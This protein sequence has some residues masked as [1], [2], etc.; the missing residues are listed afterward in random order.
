MD[1][2][3]YVAQIVAEIS[4]LRSQ[5][6]DAAV[7]RLVTSLS[8]KTCTIQHSDK[9]GPDALMGGSNY[10]ARILFHDGSSPW[11]LRVPRVTNF[12]AGLPES[13]VE[14]LVTSEHATL[15]FLENTK[16]PAPRLYAYG[17]RGTN[18]R[19]HGVGVSF[20]I[21]EH[22]PGKA[23]DGEGT[24]D[25]KAKVLSGLASIIYELSQHPF[26][27]AGSLVPDTLTS[28]RVSAVA[29]DRFLALTPHGPFD[30]AESYYTSFAEQHL[31]LICDGQLYTEYPV[32][33]YLVYRFLKESASQLASRD[34]NASAEFFLKHVDDKGDHI[35]VDEDFNITG[36]IDWE[37]ARTVPRLEAFGPSLVT[38]DMN[39]LC[40]GK[41]GL[42]EHDQIL[43]RELAKLS[44]RLTDFSVDEK[45]RRFF[46]GLAMEPAWEDAKPLAAA[47]LEV[48]GVGQ[49]W[50]AWRGDALERYKEDERL[51]R[52]VISGDKHIV[53]TE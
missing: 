35:L 34:A 26:T 40:A 16:L 43:A 5:I 4:R 3:E 53:R 14:H 33:A 42:T 32:D 15:R 49:S 7:C 13:L 10:H 23:W 6:N 19:D 46:W 38:A 2:E 28:N 8:G 9:V 27:K 39:N 30:D 21:M 51:Q 31:A 47:I 37:M 18:N 36:I 22:L 12:E 24:D 50:E 41:V 17:L 11:L 44:P 48:F 25:Q 29:S 52:L 1:D 20:L 45:V